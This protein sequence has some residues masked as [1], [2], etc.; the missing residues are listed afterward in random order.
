LRWYRYDLKN[1]INKSERSKLD[2]E[3]ARHP[4]AQQ[5]IAAADKYKRKR[6]GGEDAD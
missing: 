2:N 4:A 6:A 1:E 3:L 5:R